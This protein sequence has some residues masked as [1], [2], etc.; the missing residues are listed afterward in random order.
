MQV[1]PTDATLGAIVSG[2]SLS[3]IDAAQFAE[4]ETLW[5]RYAVLIFKDQS[6][7]GAE[8]LAF[9]RRFGL[10]EKG[11]VKK[12]ASLLAHIGNTV[13]SGDIASQDSLQV[14]FNQGNEQWHTDSSYK[15]V[16]AK[17]SLLRARSVPKQ[18]GETEWADMR[19]AYDALDEPMKNQLIGKVAVHSYR[20]SHA[21]HGGLEILS[22]QELAQLPP[23]EHA[24]VQ[25]HPGTGRK[26]LFI[27]R[28]ASHVVG[29]DIE[30]SRAMLRQLTELACQ[31]PRTYKHCWEVGDLVLWD[32]R[33]VL[34]RGHPF[35]LE[36][37]R[38]MVRSTVAGDAPD[39][40]WADQ[41][42]MG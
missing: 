26:H 34:H 3:T 33:C 18:G 40:E 30:R 15:R 6:M 4:I 42:S 23:V 35:P 9:S 31:P 12:S 36:Q 7:T 41:V 29:E 2:L 19:A 14:R 21:W 37:A 39:N 20:Y 28:H 17:A 27:G 1:T 8:Q 13:R 38:D 11:L 24:V 25:I 22:E 10:L 32:N 16:A 5:D